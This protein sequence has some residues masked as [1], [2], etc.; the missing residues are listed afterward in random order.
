MRSPLASPILAQA[1]VPIGDGRSYGAQML[2]RQE[3]ARGL[4]GWISYT[5]A[6]SQRRDA[7][8]RAF[9]LSD[10]DQSHVLTA[11]ASYALGKGFE[12]GARVRAASGMPRTPVIGALYDA[13]RDVSQPIL[14][15]TNTDRLPPFFQLDVRVSKRWDTSVGQFEA[16]LEV[17]NVTNRQNPEEIVYSSTYA[18]RDYL[19][20]LPIL[21]ILGARWSL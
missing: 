6:R 11:V 12:V 9:R 8:D 18:K 4:T 21:P 14:G 7:P 5:L 2:F 3:L 13:R 1:L 20:G 15:P 10:Y 16:Y 19:T 17:A